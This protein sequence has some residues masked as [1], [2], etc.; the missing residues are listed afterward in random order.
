[1]DISTISELI[2]QHGIIV[3]ILLLVLYGGYKLLSPYVTKKLENSA[4]S[5]EKLENNVH[6]G[7]FQ[8]VEETRDTNKQ[9]IEELKNINL[10]NQQLS[11]TN[12]ELS[13]TNRKLVES[14]DRRICTLEDVT[15]DIGKTV[16]KIN[17]KID[18]IL[19]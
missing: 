10:T 4:D 16:E 9:I 7:Y 19:K 12:Q 18:I 8:L 15:E 17:T 3:V 5:E 1:M 13:K 2:N 11:A 14:Y 6:D